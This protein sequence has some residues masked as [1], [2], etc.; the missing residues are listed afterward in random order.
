MYYA[1]IVLFAILVLAA[2]VAKIKS[3]SRAK[4]K[5][6]RGMEN[7]GDELEAGMNDG[8]DP[9]EA[10]LADIDRIEKEIIANFTASIKAGKYR[11]G[12]KKAARRGSWKKSIPRAKAHYVEKK[13]EMIEHA[14]ED[15]DDRMAL[16]QQ[17][18]DKTKGMASATSAQRITKQAAYLTELHRL[19]NAHYGRKD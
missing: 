11:G 16:I 5:M 4:A 18:L 2:S 13:E 6:E 19:M 15:Y 9:V 17:A 1:W 14:L 7:A 8:E 10:A 12:L 3:K